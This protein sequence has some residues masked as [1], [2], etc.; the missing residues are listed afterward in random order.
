MPP[1]IKWS[2]KFQIKAGVWV[3]V[4]TDES[5]VVGLQFKNLIESFWIAPD[6]YYHLRDGG[7]VRALREH[8]KHKF[9]LHLDIKNFFGQINRSRITRS[10]KGYFSYK[11][12]REIAVE[13]TVR[14]PELSEAKYILPF[15]FVQSPIIAS[16]C[17][18]KS[19]LG[20]YLSRLGRR[21][22]FSVSVY[23]DDILVSCDDHD[24]LSLELA[25]IEAAAEKSAL[26]L[27]TEKQEGPGIC[28]T[29]FN[30]Q[31]SHDL[32][33]II[34][35]RLDELASVHSS[36]TNKSQREGILNYVLSVNPIQADLLCK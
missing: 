35:D 36:S 5:I 14:Q 1:Y 34:P 10:L 6:H 22:G 23:M 27:N 31:L 12:A 25:K 11:E 30:I 20:R 26:P 15:G 18:S 4:P 21:K 9:F 32:L 2:S 17:L 7:H 16:V 24:V 3:F 13:S 33:E 28:V 19:A 8:T 29:A